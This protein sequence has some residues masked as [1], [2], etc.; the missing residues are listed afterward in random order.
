M[1]EVCAE[2]NGPTP[3]IESIVSW[4]MIICRQHNSEEVNA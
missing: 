2:L 3:Y 4:A 1:R